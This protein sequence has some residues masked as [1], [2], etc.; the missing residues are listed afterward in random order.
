MF[1]WILPLLFLP[2]SA[3]AIESIILYNKTQDKV[4]LSQNTEILRPIASVT[5]LMTA[6]VIL[7]GS[8]MLDE[9][10]KL[11]NKI[12]SNLPVREYSRAELLNAMLVRSDNAAAET[13]ASNYQG[14]REAFITAMNSKA[15]SIGMYNTSFD[16]A[17]G[18]SRLNISTAEDVSVMLM[19]AF[20]YEYIR[21]V[22]VKKQVSFQVPTKNKNKLFELPNTNTPILSLFNN[23]E[24]SKTGYTT[25]AGFCLA[26]VVH[27]GA[28][29]FSVVILGSDNKQSRF[30]TA[31]KI[32]SNH[33]QE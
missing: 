11:Q 2:T 21:N 30:N 6:M 23:I 15:K 33:L 28:D 1:R 12:K 17:S 4:L 27:K 19:E 18:L 22:S 26:M 16:D 3:N 14:G 24:V 20:G 9:K 29:L 13:L 7:D 5:K 32:L 25:P 10:I 31:K 8:Q